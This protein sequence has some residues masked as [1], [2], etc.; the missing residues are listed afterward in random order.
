MN[1]TD[2]VYVYEKLKSE[3]G[4]GSIIVRAIFCQVFS[5]SFWVNIKPAGLSLGKFYGHKDFTFA[6]VRG[7]TLTRF[8]SIIK[9]CYWY[10]N[11]RTRHK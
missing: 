6:Q 1:D 9:I 3:R 8:W 2:G 7:Y 5:E 11:N 10:D 4:I